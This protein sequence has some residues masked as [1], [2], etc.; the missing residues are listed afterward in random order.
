MLLPSQ[1]DA[2]KAPLPPCFHPTADYSS[3]LGY[4]SIWTRYSWLECFLS[5]SISL[6][7][8]SEEIETGK[9][10]KKDT[11]QSKLKDKCK[12]QRATNT[13]MRN[14]NVFAGNELAWP[15]SFATPSPPRCSMQLAPHEAKAKNG[16]NMAKRQII[17][18]CRRQRGR[19]WQR[20]RGRGVGR[21]WGRRW[22]R[23]SHSS[24]KKRKQDKNCK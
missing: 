23:T 24:G 5:C 21:G 22:L 17:H 20:R 1:Q 12:R 6:F 16:E 7:F 2:S 14:E 11:L 10:K 3:V 13:A 15:A 9:K 18:T 4:L 19:L 8:L